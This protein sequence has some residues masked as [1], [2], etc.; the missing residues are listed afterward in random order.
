[1]N[2]ELIKELVVLAVE[3]NVG[4]N[5]DPDYNRLTVKTWNE[6]FLSGDVTSCDAPAQLQAAIDKIKEL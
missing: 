4:F 2:T 1:M 6:L 5:Y 3:N